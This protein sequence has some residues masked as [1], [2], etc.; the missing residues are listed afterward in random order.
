MLFVDRRL[1]MRVLIQQNEEDE[2]LR[3]YDNVIKHEVSEG[4]LWLH[5]PGGNLIGI[6]LQRVYLVSLEK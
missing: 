2:E 1:K 3:E 4:Y 5:F 6:N